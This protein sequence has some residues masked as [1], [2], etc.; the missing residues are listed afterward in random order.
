MR[1]GKRKS[2]ADLS[3]LERLGIF[4]YGSTCN[5]ERSVEAGRE[6]RAGKTLFRGAGSDREISRAR[7]SPEKARE[8]A[9]GR[10]RFRRRSTNRRNSKRLRDRAWQVRDSDRRGSRETG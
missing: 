10:S 9:H 7:R 5:V 2:R 6:P 3:R 1:T 4:F 8:A